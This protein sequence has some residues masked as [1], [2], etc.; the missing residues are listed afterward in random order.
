L[1]SVVVEVVASAPDVGPAVQPVVAGAF[2]KVI[3]GPAADHGVVAGAAVQVAAVI[4]VY[5][6]IVSR[7]AGDPGVR[8]NGWIDPDPVVAS[9]TINSQRLVKAGRGQFV[10]GAVEQ[11]LA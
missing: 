1:R 3:A 9:A 7:A 6:I 8:V 4:R 11:D 10:R 2:E 5:D